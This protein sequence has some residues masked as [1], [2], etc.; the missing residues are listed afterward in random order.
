MTRTRGQ[1]VLVA[2][3]VVAVAL[4]PMVFAYLQLGYH[5]DVE[6]G[7]TAD[8]LDDA[9][10]TLGHAT[11]DA[12]ENVSGELSWRRRERAAARVDASLSRTFR[13]LEA[14][15][16]GAQVVFSVGYNRS[17]AE[18]WVGRRCPSGPRREFGP[19]LVRRGIV[20]QER[21]GETHALAVAV[22]VRV[23]GERR[24]T[25][26]TFVVLDTGRTDARARRDGPP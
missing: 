5:A 21:A 24:T 20:L 26:A 6:G 22:D 7:A 15:S 13:R 1:L 14:G 16:S 2:A 18:E 17:A 12:S 9:R 23:V 19:C 11:R 10:A 25:E 8:H 3:A 4:V